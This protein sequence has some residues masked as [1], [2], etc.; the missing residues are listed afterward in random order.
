MC[1]PQQV[2]GRVADQGLCCPVFTEKKTERYTAVVSVAVKAITVARGYISNEGTGHELG[3]QPYLRGGDA[4]HHG[5]GGNGGGCR[6]TC[7]SV[8]VHV[9]TH[10]HTHTHTHI[11]THTKTHT[12]TYTHKNTLTHTHEN[13][14]THTKTHSHTRKHTHTHTHTHTETR[15][16]TYM[17]GVAAGVTGLD[18]AS[19]TAVGPGAWVVRGWR[20]S[21]Y[22]TT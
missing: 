7:T 1:L 4:Y 5:L 17:Q 11:Q 14:L 15:T 9:H 22:K 13:T 18:Q 10:T 16:H 6:H 2:L 19:S 21:P 12:H 3:F 20:S 8:H